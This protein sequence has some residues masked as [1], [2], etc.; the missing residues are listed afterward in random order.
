MCAK[1]AVAM[2]KVHA[3]LAE[4]RESSRVELSYDV[5]GQLEGVGFFNGVD[6]LMSC[7]TVYHLERD[8]DQPNMPELIR[9]LLL[10]EPACSAAINALFKF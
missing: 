3:Y 9:A 10:P 1:L 4:L 7:I 5:D 8:S 6:D 2:Q